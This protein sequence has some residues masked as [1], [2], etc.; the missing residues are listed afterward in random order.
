MIY[1]WPGCRSWKNV[2]NLS[3]FG[4]P[5]MIP[6]WTRNPPCTCNILASQ[7]FA[8]TIDSDFKNSNVII[9]AVENSPN[10]AFPS[11]IDLRVVIIRSTTSPIFFSENFWE[12]KISFSSSLEYIKGAKPMTVKYPSNWRL[13]S[14]NSLPG[15]Q[16]RKAFRKRR[17]C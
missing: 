17:N 9:N 10:A 4:N 7:S 11:G 3:C 6:F 15:M 5:F 8:A 14:P 12:S 13:C 16:S 1:A 2:G